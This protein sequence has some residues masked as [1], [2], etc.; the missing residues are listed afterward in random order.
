MKCPRCNGPIFENDKFCGE[1]GNDLRDVTAQSDG[2]VPESDYQESVEFGRAEH[3]QYGTSTT[4]ATTVNQPTYLNE[5]FEFIKSAIVSPENTVKEKHI[6]SPWIST[7][8]PTALL[9]LLSVLT[10]IVLRL[11]T[12]PSAYLEVEIS[13][14]F[15]VFFYSILTFSLFYLVLLLMNK[16][17]VKNPVPWDKVL[18]DYALLSVIVIG[19]YIMAVLLLWIK[20]Y[21]ISLVVSLIGS[22]IFYIAPIYIFLK[23][24]EYNNSKLDTFYSLFI[25]I[26][27]TAVAYYIVIRM[28][29][30]EIENTVAPYWFY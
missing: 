21:E 7:L 30:A 3:S 8:V 14:M 10:L 29:I 5:A 17:I 11:A 16:W 15:Q 18:N 26:I 4:E 22:I 1:C 28:V 19:S 20:L 2:K 23:Y 25:Y 9:F 6:A 13:V 24:A 27:L 12:A